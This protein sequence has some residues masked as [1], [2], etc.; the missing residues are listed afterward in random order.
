MTLDAIP[1]NYCYW[2][3][4]M[5]LQEVGKD[6]GKLGSGKGYKTND[7]ANLFLAW[8][9]I[10]L[11]YS[12]FQFLECLIFPQVPVTV[13]VAA[14][15]RHKLVLRATFAFSPMNWWRKWHLFTCFTFRLATQKSLKVKVYLIEEF[16]PWIFNL[17][18]FRMLNFPP[19][20]L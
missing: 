2:H 1:S 18:V 16:Q 10:N 15:D 5:L 8:K 6:A 11:E 17:S 19:K 12:T 13:E 9:N 3:F 14:L 4:V 20:S 7:F